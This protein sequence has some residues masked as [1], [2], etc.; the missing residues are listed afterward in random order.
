[1]VYRNI[2]VL[3]GQ[4][5]FQL[6]LFKFLMYVLYEDPQFYN[7]LLRPLETTH[8]YRTRGGT[9]RQP[10][11]TCEVQRRGVVNQLVLKLSEAN[12]N[13]FTNLHPQAAIRKYKRSLLRYQ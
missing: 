4:N 6:Q 1:M 13:E 12:I 11:L 8:A 5:I 9:Y 7:L 3:T 10:M 2:N